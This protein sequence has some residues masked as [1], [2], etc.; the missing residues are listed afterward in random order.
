MQ[1][2]HRSCYGGWFRTYPLCAC[3]RASDRDACVNLR[4]IRKE[5]I[6]PSP[7]MAPNVRKNGNMNESV[8]SIALNARNPTANRV[9]KIAFRAC[10][11]ATSGKACLFLSTIAFSDL[12]SS[13][14]LGVHTTPTSESFAHSVHVPLKQNLHVPTASDCGCLKHF[15]FIL[16]NVTNKLPTDNVIC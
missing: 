8:R 5:K 1:R 12:T 7:K 2:C 4:P 16:R 11:L 10:V 15:T 3:T 6:A 13:W 14:H 9:S